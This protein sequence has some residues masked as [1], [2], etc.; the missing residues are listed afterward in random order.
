MGQ[1]R[2]GSQDQRLPAKHVV[3]MDLCRKHDNFN[4]IALPMIAISNLVYFFSSSN[5]S[6]F[7][8]FRD[9][10]S[11]AYYKLNVSDTQSIPWGHTYVFWLFCIYM[12]ADIVWLTVKPETVASPQTIVVH[13][14]FALMGVLM[15]VLEQRWSWWCSLG[16]LV[17]INTVFLLLRRRYPGIFVIDAS[18]AITWIGIRN[19]I[20]PISTTA[21]VFEYFEYS[22]RRNHNYINSGGMVLGTMLLLNFLFVKWTLNF[23]QGQKKDKGL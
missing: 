5:W 4:L 22:A 10:L 18:F 20:Y 9:G 7:H 8:P 1:T 2:A 12:V 17:E 6:A 23:I 21:F 14:V 3:D 13:H 11:A 19:V 16:L 15:G